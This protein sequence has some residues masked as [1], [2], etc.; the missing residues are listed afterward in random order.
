MEKNRASAYPKDRA[1]Y[2]IRGGKEPGWFQWWM[3]PV[4]VSILTWLL[5][6]HVLFIGFVP[7]E[8]MEPTLKKGSCL[9]AERSGRDYGKGDII[10]FWKKG[11]IHVKRIF[12]AGGDQVNLFRL[13]CISQEETKEAR[14][15]EESIVTVPKDC[16]FV[17]GDNR[18]HSID[19]RYWKD[20]FV[21]R[22]DVIGKVLFCRKDG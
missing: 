5:F 6:H 8:S 2:G 16:F 18:E 19:S 1:G 7:T 12:A 14:V 4:F 17:L 15:M 13:K 11:S 9:L 22:E 20:R 3:L 21:K 10:V